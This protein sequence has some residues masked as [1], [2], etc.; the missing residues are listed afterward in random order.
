MFDQNTPDWLIKVTFLKGAEAAVRQGIGSRFSN[1]GHFGP[2]VFSLTNGIQIL[3]AP[4]SSIF[5]S[6]SP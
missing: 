1:I 2:V 6:A 5:L 3:S 4:L